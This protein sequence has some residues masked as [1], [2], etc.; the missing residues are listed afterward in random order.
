M[1]REIAKLIK[2]LDELRRE[3]PELEFNVDENAKK[4]TIIYDFLSLDKKQRY[5][6]FDFERKLPSDVEV[7]FIR[8][9][10][11]SYEAV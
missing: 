7:E 6:L 4:I 9:Y 8:P 2:L 1:T 5:K 10:N 11:T 3:F